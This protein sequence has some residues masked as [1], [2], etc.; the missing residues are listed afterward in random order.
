[1]LDSGGNA[2]LSVLEVDLD[3]WLEGWVENNFSGPGAA[4]SA[5]ELQSQA[6]VRTA[7]AAVAGE[8]VR[9]AGGNLASYLAE[10]QVTMTGAPR[11]S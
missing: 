10:R 1:V 9:A 3:Q 2:F 7:G 8:L 11:A 4:Q 6:D 5:T